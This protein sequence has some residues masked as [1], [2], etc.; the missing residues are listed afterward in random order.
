MTDLAHAYRILRLEPGVSLREIVEA[1]D[2]LLYLWDPSRMA[3]RPRLRSRAQKEQAEIQ[4]AAILLLESLSTGSRESSSSESIPPR[5]KPE[6]PSLYDEFF[7]PERKN[8]WVGLAVTAGFIL[9]AVV[10]LLMWL[11]PNSAPAPVP[12]QTTSGEEESTPAEPSPTLTDPSTASATTKPPLERSS[13]TTEPTSSE[14]GQATPAARPAD[15]TPA[16]EAAP[17]TQPAPKARSQASSGSRPV[18]LRGAPPATSEPS[19]A[20]S[21]AS[22]PG[23]PSSSPPPNPGQLPAGSSPPPDPGQPPAVSSIPAVDL[24]VVFD[25]LLEQSRAA[26]MLAGGRFPDLPFSGW[27]V[28][29]KRDDEFYVDLAIEKDGTT[30]HFIW[31]VNSEEE[32]AR[33]LSQA[34]RDLEAGTNSPEQP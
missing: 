3:D 4:A 12:E 29:E 34:A 18:L 20:T 11:G 23:Q 1:R 8:S 14:T 13:T 25:L 9:V 10:A 31:G 33:P 5:S 15:Q 2:D 28:L 26:R 19:P 6:N 30:V 16:P 21:P 22:G 24:Q 7:S 32:S 17:A 27:K